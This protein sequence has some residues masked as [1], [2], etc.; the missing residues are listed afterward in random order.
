VGPNNDRI[1]GGTRPRNSAIVSSAQVRSR[2]GT[3]GVR[4]SSVPPSSSNPVSGGSPWSH[5]IMRGSINACANR[6]SAE[7]TSKVRLKLST[8]NS[9][10]RCTAPT[11]AAPRPAGT[12][13]RSGHPAGTVVA[14][15]VYARVS[16][17]ESALDGANQ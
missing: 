15:Q 1:T 12:I 5:A 11:S 3:R 17:G 2:S 8:S 10:S 7:R 9:M 13:E 16:L 14:A 6:R 4:H